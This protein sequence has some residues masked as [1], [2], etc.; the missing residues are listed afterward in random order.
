MFCIALKYPIIII[1]FPAIFA[2]SFYKSI[3][4]A[5]YLLNLESYQKA[6]INKSKPAL[7]CNGQCAVVSR[8]KSQEEKRNES[9]PS[10]ELNTQE[11]NFF[12]DSN[13]SFDLTALPNRQKRY[14]YF[15]ESILNQLLKNV[16]HPP[17]SSSSI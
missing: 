12:V 4:W 10:P 2:Q 9:S 5:D 13:C 7:K 15:I 16:F 3:Q 1:L 17:D 8:W 11:Y 14:H 6:C